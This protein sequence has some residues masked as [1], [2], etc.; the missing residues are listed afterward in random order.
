MDCS[1][2]ELDDHFAKLETKWSEG[3]QAGKKF[4]AYF[5][6]HKLDSVR[7]CMLLEKRFLSGLGLDA[8][9]QN[10]SECMN[11]VIKSYIGKNELDVVEFVEKMREL[12]NL[13]HRKSEIACYKEVDGVSLHESY[14]HLRIF[15][16]DLYGSTQRIDRPGRDKVLR[17]IHGAALNPPSVRQALEDVSV[18]RNLGSRF[19][20]WLTDI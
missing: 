19:V 10:Q 12:S 18:V 15:D 17:R 1:S 5:K 13:Q 9:T 16:V 20:L 4:A 3:S 2:D 7:N 8:Y 6:V 11:H 14:S